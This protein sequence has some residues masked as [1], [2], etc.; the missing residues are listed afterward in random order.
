M[1]STLQKMQ[2]KDAEWQSLNPLVATALML[3]A[4]WSDAFG[5]DS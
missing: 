4:D 2:I 5:F 1:E 3:Y